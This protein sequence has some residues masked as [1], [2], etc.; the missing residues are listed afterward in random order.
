MQIRS[1][2]IDLG[3]TTFHHLSNP[4]FLASDARAQ[5]SRIRSLPT[6]TSR[7]PIRPVLPGSPYLGSGRPVSQLWIM[8]LA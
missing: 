8:Y 1:V 3:K 4:T 7:D 6:R 5:K 2:G